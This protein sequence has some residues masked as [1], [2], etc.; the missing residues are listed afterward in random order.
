[1][2][3]EHTSYFD[4]LVS[5]WEL[6]NKTAMNNLIKRCLFKNIIKKEAYVSLI[7]EVSNWNGRKV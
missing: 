4:D 2:Q 7:S 3:I 6:A 5:G 1:M